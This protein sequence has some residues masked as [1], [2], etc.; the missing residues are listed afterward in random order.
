MLFARSE[1]TPKLKIHVKGETVHLIGLEKK[2]R[3]APPIRAKSA[4]YSEGS[5]LQ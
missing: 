1:F 3:A 4:D 5:L 2:V